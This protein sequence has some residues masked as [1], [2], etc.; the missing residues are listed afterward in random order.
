MRRRKEG[1]RTVRSADPD[2]GCA[3]I[4]IESAFFVDFGGRIGGGKDLNADLWGACEERFLGNLGPTGIEPG[5][6]DS[7][8]TVGDRDRAISKNETSREQLGQKTANGKLTARVAE[9]WRRT[10][11]DASEAIGLDPVREP[12]ERG[13]SQ[14]LGPAIQVEPRLRCKVR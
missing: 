9:S 5:D 13:V 11:E 1:N 4:E 8:D 3:R 7:L 10:H 12:G 14:D 2:L 6:I